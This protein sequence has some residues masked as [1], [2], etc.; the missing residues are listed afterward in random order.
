MNKKFKKKS[1][2]IDDTVSPRAREFRRSMAKL[3]KKNK[4]KGGEEE[5]PYEFC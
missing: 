5:P 4:R 3:E 2:N 1:N